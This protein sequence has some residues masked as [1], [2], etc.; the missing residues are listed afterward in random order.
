M[1]TMTAW[2]AFQSGED[3]V[4]VREEVLASWHRSRWSGVD[5]GLREA[6]LADVEDDTP[7]VRS[8]APVLLRMADLLG[9]SRTSL[10]VAD[11]AGHVVWRWTSDAA[12]GD[13]LDRSGFRLGAGFGE[14]QVG[15]CGIG[16]ALE[17]RTVASVL[18]SE[19]FVESFHRW[20]CVAA[21]VVDQT[22]GRVLGAVNVLSRDEDA[23]RFMQVAARSLA[24][25]VVSA[26]AA[27]SSTSEQRLLHAV[28]RAR[29]RTTA[30]LIA[31]T[32]HVM[33]SDAA[34]VVPGVEHGALWSHVRDAR[35]GVEAVALGPDI[36]A[37]VLR[38]G[39][40][41]T[42]GVVL[43]L[44]RVPPGACDAPAR[45]GR[46][47]SP[48]EEAEAGVIAS[49]LRECGGN[50][51][52]AAHRLGISRGTLYKKLRLYRTSAP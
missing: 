20:A 12:L 13:D 34:A 35:P 50:K 27:A 43:A 45:P 26:V 22:T 4:G 44:R 41:V 10:A 49:M 48:L 6:P 28:A 38:V 18:G 11:A 17:S 46:R 31:L 2:D 25:Q 52:T 32:E 51:T 47:F 29:R 14:K 42:D 5:P 39:E 16:T 1:S 15:T 24:D 7:L 23:N 37:N 21:P 30:P 33:L 40:A 19:H 3:P 8:A 9:D 36:V